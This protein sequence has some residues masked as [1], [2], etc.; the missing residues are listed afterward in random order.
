[1]KSEGAE[2]GKGGWGGGGAPAAADDRHH[3]QQKE[4]AQHFTGHNHLAHLTHPTFARSQKRNNMFRAGRQQQQAVQKLQC[5]LAVLLDSIVH[6]LHK[7]AVEELEAARCDIFRKL[8][9]S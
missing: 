2:G 4:Q 9:A 5:E 7:R 1:M 6:E 8:L 3:C